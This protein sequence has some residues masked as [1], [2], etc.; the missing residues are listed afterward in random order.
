M[1]QNKSNIELSNWELVSV[2]P[3]KKDWNWKDLFCFWANNIQTI[4]GFSLIASFYLL[5]DL[6]III[7]F[8]GSLA[9]VILVIFFSNLIGKP[10]QKHGIPFPVFL[11]IS[12]G[13]NG[14]RYIAILRGIVATFMFGVQTFFLSKSFGYLIRI[15]LFKY[16]N[17]FQEQEIF[18][19][20]YF[21]L[22]IIDWTS[23]ILTIFLQVYLFKKGQDFIKGFINF[24]AIFVYIGLII[25]CSIIASKNFTEVTNL[26]ENIFVLENIFKKSNVGPLLSVCGTMFAYFSIVIVNFGDFSRFVKNESELKKGNATLVFNLIFF[27]IFSIFIVLG[28]DIILNKS[29][30]D[31][32]KILTNPTDIIGKFDNTFLTVIVLCFIVFATASTNLIANFIPSKYSLINFAPKILNS[33][34]SGILI[35]LIALLVGG[36]WLSILSQVGVL[37]IIDTIA[38]FFGPIFG[39]VIADYYFIKKKELVNKDIFS[40]NKDSAYYFSG[41]WHIRAIFSLII[42]FIFSAATIWNAELRYLQSFSWL[43]GATMGFIMYY[44]VSKK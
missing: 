36:F 30:T 25:F 15:S 5:Y 6:N 43:I 18:S 2:N 21:G 12:M 10:S 34:S 20:F 33:N 1:I 29:F 41:G 3:N 40:S 23:L 39:I 37:S 16:D 17:N 11:R 26:I 14:A 13:I 27:S 24:S 22:D 35:G 7:V 9:A 38:T 4:I 19:Y 44:L 42:A 31:L 8:F 28:A 32:D